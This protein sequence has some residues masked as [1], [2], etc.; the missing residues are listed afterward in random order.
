MSTVAFDLRHP[1]LVAHEIASANQRLARERE[2]PASIRV[3]IED[4][5]DALEESDPDELGADPYLLLDVQRTVTRAL[6]ASAEGDP[7][8]ER[9]AVRLALEHLRFL[10]ARL[11]EDAPVSEERPAKEVARWLATRLDVP[12]R[13][14]ADLVGVHE[15][16]FQ[17]WASDTE[18]SEPSGEDAR[19]LRAVAQLAAQLRFALTGPGV[20]A[21]F[22]RP[23]DELGGQPPATLLDEPGSIT[24]LRRAARAARGSYAT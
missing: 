15:R 19:R 11:A 17:R 22:G 2:V 23:R 20:I 6:R 3:L 8:I 9:R 10:F 13:V 12:Q 24:E 4:L 7:L 18:G 1:D 21:W 14:L 5:A 16:T